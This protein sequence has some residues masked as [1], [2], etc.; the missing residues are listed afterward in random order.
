MK[1]SRSVEGLMGV[2]D[3]ANPNLRQRAVDAED[4][5]R[6]A[7]VRDQIRALEPTS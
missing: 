5:E 3:H 1:D 4:F 7:Q 2:L 6:A